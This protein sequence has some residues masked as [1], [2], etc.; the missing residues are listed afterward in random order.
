VRWNLLLVA[1]A[2]SWGFV[3]IIAAA[4][5]L[6]AEVLV[7]WRCLLAAASLPVLL[8]ALGRLA[9]IRLDRHR[10]RVLALGALLALHWF[11]FFAAVKRSS[12]AVA[13]LT[14]YTA[15]IFVAV[16][17]PRVLR[18]RRSPVALLALAISAPGLVV[19][20]LAGD[21]GA[22]PEAVA[23]AFGLGAALTYALL[24]VGVK[25]I[26]ADVS[27]FVLAFWQY[28]VVSAAL[29]P[30]LLGA[31]RVVPSGDE[32]AAVLV[33]GLVLT[34]GMG[35]LYVWNLRHVTA[36]A[37]GLLAYLEPVSASLLAWAILDQTLGWQVAL[38]GAA[39][40]AG[41]TLVVVYEGADAP[42]IEAPTP[43]AEDRA[44]LAEQ[45][46]STV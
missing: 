6:P 36:Q 13:I 3:S 5:E 4:V 31:E 42:S 41:G 16:L 2:A 1:V 38:G 11:L 35:A 32:W 26:T 29:A 37:A 27:P 12:V 46:A 18:E 19:I 22:R 21:G 20:A 24:I 15:P 40:V 30:F 34:G 45:P 17:A 28:V 23:I 44:V 33:L 7:F 14:V 8:L 43:V 9:S 39:V 10:V 25:S